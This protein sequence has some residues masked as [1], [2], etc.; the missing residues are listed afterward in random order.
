MELTNTFTV[1]LPV[2]QTWDVLLDLGRVIPCLPGAAV[3]SLDGDA[4]EG[5]VKIKV[6]PVSAQYKGAGRFAEKDQT[7][8][9]AV[10][11]AEGKDVGGQGNAKA[12]ITATLS[13]QGSGTAVH[14]LTD[15]ALSGRAANFGRGVIADVSNKILGQFVKNLEAEIARSGVDGTAATPTKPTSID[16]VEPLDVMGSMGSTVMKYALPGAGA[17][18]AVLALIFALTRRGR[19]AGARYT[20]QSAHSGGY[21]GISSG[22]PLV[23]NLVF[24]APSASR[25][26]RSGGSDFARALQP[27]NGDGEATR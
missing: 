26:E 17:L 16:D 10:I 8:R 22:V 21:T 23:I 11:E 4:F 3:L 15:L 20:G 12:T 19:G 7:N 2:A 1:D 5:A 18:A 25:D 27:F 9:R 14:V 6:G 13:E 24:P